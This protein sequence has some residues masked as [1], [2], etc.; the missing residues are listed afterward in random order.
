MKRIRMISMLGVVAL[1]SACSPADGDEANANEG[2]LSPSVAQL[3]RLQKLMTRLSLRADQRATLE[4]MVKD[5]ATKLGP[6]RKLRAEAVAEVARQLRAGTVDRPRLEA[7]LKR[8]EAL[9]ASLRPTLLVAMNNVHRTLDASQRAKLVDQLERR[10]GRRHGHGHGLRALREVARKLKLSDDQLDR[11]QAVVKAEAGGM[12]ERLSRMVKLYDQLEDAKQAFKGDR[13]NA[14]DLEIL[15][16][17]PGLVRNRI[18]SA[19][20]AAEKILPILSAE[21]RAAAAKLLEEHAR[22]RGHGRW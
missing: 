2:A 8:A 3:A 9:H 12:G 15:K 11:I 5:L 4:T 7:L 19:I 20:K 18:E 14:A 10:G 6:A 16:A 17:V 22:K 1:L 21:Q 13:F